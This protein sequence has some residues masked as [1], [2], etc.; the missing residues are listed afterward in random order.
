MEHRNRGVCQ[1]DLEWGK[2]RLE[3]KKKTLVLIAERGMVYFSP[4]LFMSSTYGV[5]SHLMHGCVRQFRGVWELLEL[6]IEIKLWNSKL[7]RQSP[8]PPLNMGWLTVHRYS[9]LLR[10]THWMKSYLFFHSQPPIFHYWDWNHESPAPS[11]TLALLSKLERAGYW[12]SCWACLGMFVC[13]FACLEG[14]C[15][16]TRI[17]QRPIVGVRDWY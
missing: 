16:C 15:L 2:F 12:T 1:R 5:S 7:G 8:R 11:L 13:M 14:G 17:S 6:G 10:C 4:R 9:V 3:E